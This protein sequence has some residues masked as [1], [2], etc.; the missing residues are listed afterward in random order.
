M[1]MEPGILKFIGQSI[2]HGVIVVYNVPDPLRTHIALPAGQCLVF[3][4]QLPIRIVLLFRR[5]KCIHKAD[6]SPPWVR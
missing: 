5:R 6:F 1:Q 4:R 2:R 3:F